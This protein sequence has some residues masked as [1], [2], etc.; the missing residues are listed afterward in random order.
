M[1]L[2]AFM[3][4]RDPREQQLKHNTQIRKPLNLHLVGS[5]LKPFERI[6]VGQPYR[7]LQWRDEGV[8]HPQYAAFGHR[9]STIALF[10]RNDS[11]GRSLRCSL[12]TPP[13]SSVSHDVIKVDGNNPGRFTEQADYGYRSQFDRLCRV[14]CR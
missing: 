12:A 1:D 13:R 3:S 10:R 14:S 2:S 8:K 4:L 5:S 9:L 11:R 6:I 7:A